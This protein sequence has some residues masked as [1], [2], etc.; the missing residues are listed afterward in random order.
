MLARRAPKHARS[1]GI[2]CVGELGLFFGSIDRS[3][4]SR[5]HYYVG[6]RE[7]DSPCHGFG[8]AEIDV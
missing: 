2:H 8:V 7:T 5:I 1:D 3:V 6:P 4:R